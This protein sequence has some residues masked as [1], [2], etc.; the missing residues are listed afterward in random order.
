MQLLSGLGDKF[1][2]TYPQ[3]RDGENSVVVGDC[4][5]DDGDFVLTAGLLHQP[6]ELGD[7]HGR[8]VDAGHKQTPQ[9]NLVELG[10]GTAGQKA[11]EL[12]QQPQVD[13]L[14]FRLGTP[15]LAVLIVSYVDSLEEGN[16][17]ILIEP[18]RSCSGPSI[19]VL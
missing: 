19:A 11:V 18:L 3:L 5:D 9:D 8:P 17:A 15:D 13:V 2:H 12:D 10:V 4:S 16:I 1:H 6:G 14:R 7:G